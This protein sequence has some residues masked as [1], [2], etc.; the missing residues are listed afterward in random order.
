MAAYLASISAM[1]LCGGVCAITMDA[2]INVAN[3]N[4]TRPV[5]FFMMVMCAVFAVN[6]GLCL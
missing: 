3:K 4:A 5:L 2:V 6:E 1:E